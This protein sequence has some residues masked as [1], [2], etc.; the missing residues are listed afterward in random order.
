V[1]PGNGVE[2]K[3]LTT[4]RGDLGVPVASLGHG[5]SWTIG[6]G[7]S[8]EEPNQSCKGKDGTRK[9]R[10]IPESCQRGCRPDGSPEGHKGSGS[11]HEA[12][13]KPAILVV[14]QR[15]GDQK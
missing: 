14:E 4:R 5:K 9:P 3:T 11:G 1:K 6:D 8:E 12:T 10:G 7:D 2:D 15:H 13:C